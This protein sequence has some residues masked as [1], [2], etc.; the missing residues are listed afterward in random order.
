MPNATKTPTPLFKDMSNEAL[1]EAYWATRALIANADGM[2]TM[3]A[4]CGARRSASKSIGQIFR[5]QRNLD[6]IVAVSR[7]RGISLARQVVNA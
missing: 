6:I 4:E 7:K 2:A 5:Q 3:M 1:V